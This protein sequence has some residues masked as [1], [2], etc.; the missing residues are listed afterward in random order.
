MLLYAHGQM[1]DWPDAESSY[2]PYRVKEVM[3]VSSISSEGIA[4]EV[5]RY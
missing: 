1:N 4:L 5:A 2:R 3:P